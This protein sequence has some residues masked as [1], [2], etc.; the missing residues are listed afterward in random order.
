MDKQHTYNQT[1]HNH[2]N[3]KTCKK[4]TQANTLICTNIK[5]TPTP[6][7]EGDRYNIHMRAP[8]LMY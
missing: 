3:T 5:K 6:F 8:D 2:M 4:Q 7:G 1:Y